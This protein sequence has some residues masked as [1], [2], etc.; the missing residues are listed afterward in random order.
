MANIAHVQIVK[1]GRDVVAKWREEN[2]GENLD[3]FNC[4]LSH[5]RI[6]M[7]D[8]HG[9][10]LRESDF[11][12]AML[13]RA[14][15][16]GCYLNP[17]H[18]YRADLREADL[19][20]TLL[21]GANLRGAN[22]AGA[23][24]EQANLDA[25]ILSGANLT[26]ANLRRANLTR[27]NLSGANLTDADLTEANFS[28]AALNRSN[29]SGA[30][31]TETDFYEAVFNDTATVGA[32]FAGAIVGYTVFQN[33]DLSTAEDLDK[34]RHDAPSTVGIDTI[35]RSSGKIAEAFLAGIGAPH[36]L[37]S[38]LKTLDESNTL[39]GEYYI[40][41]AEADVPFAEGLR[42][43]LRS[44]GVRAWVFAENFRGNALVDRRS[45]SEEEEIERWVRHYDKLIVVCSQAGLD[46][47]S[48]RTDM[49]QARDLQ[50]TKDQWLIYLADPDGTLDKPTAR[51]ARN[52]TYENVIFD[53]RGQSENT[54]EYQQSLSKLVEDLKQ[55]QP[56]K[57]GIPTASASDQL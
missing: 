40:S 22:L 53:L 16:A 28:G 26:G 49:T 14:N 41:C 31:L 2:P 21:N 1:Q 10:D 36:E 43:N 42:D 55:S 38:F 32:K 3:L 18:L 48:V 17:A 9:C 57:A 30:N 5:A 11:M 25:A 54:A 45:T 33:C 56:A 51:S 23:N 34:V 29:L 7:V 44:Q 12:G 39:S 15:L 4:F 19:S 47:E 35:F 13:R 6:P 8:L 24:L 46:S 52:L 20:R 50:Q 27:V 37:Y